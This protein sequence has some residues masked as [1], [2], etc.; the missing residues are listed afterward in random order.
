VSGVSSLGA[1][2]PW[3]RSRVARTRDQL[4]RYLRSPRT[5][6]GAILLGVVVLVALL[7]PAFAPFTPTEFVAPPFSP[8]STDAVLGTDNLGRDVLS[9]LLWGGRSVLALS[10]LSAG[11]GV[12]VGVAIGLAAGYA[13]SSIDDALM[14]MTDVV[15]AFPQIVLA[16]L[17]VSMVGPK[18]WL[19]VLV[20]ALSHAPRVAR[21][22]RTLTFE[23]VN[24]EYVESAEI[25][26]MPRRRIIVREILPNLTTPLMVEFGLRLTWSIGI[27]AGLSFLGFG[28]QPPN[29][30]WGL[31]INENRGGLELQPWAVVM[32]IVMIAIYTVAANLVTEG[33][34][35]T[36]AGIDREGGRA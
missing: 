5:A 7:G 13:R 30:D 25:L 4:A 14:R 33:F 28:I 1:T 15:L 12:V 35:R 19:I 23:A 9:R 31:M 2:E 26:G 36:V 3:N 10:F 16:L 24:R 27:I 17:V 18:V 21:L 8:P 32:P 20:V 11:L 6:V 29:A 22:A 34:S